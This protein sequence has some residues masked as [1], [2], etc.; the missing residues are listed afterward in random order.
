MSPVIESGAQE[1]SVVQIGPLR[2]QLCIEETRRFV[3]SLFDERLQEN[4]VEKSKVD[5]RRDDQVRLIHRQILHSLP[6]KR[7]P[8]SRRGAPTVG[9]V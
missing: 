8:Q 2:F 4:F 9:D 1:R 7:Q 5:P 6:A 3:D